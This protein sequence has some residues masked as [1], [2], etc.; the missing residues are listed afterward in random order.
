[1]SSPY[2]DEWLSTKVMGLLGDVDTKHLTSEKQELFR[3]IKRRAFA[4]ESTQSDYMEV[5]KLWSFQHCR[6][7]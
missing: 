1:M 6:T 5:R 3:E 7:M 4:D 2:Y